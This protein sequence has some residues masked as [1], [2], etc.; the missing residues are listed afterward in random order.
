MGG[1][2][3]A[4]FQALYKE[5]CVSCLCYA[6]NNSAKLIQNEIGGKCLI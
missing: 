4:V 3:P 5:I 2:G 6:E 1:G